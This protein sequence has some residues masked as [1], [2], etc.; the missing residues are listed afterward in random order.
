MSIDA[1]TGYCLNVELRTNQKLLGFTINEKKNYP[2]TDI[3]Q[4][5]YI[6]PIV[7]KKFNGGDEVYVI[8]MFEGDTMRAKVWGINE[9]EPDEWDI[10]VDDIE[11]I[12]GFAGVVG[13]GFN[14]N[15]KVTDFSVKTIQPTV[16]LALDPENVVGGGYVTAVVLAKGFGG[17]D[18]LLRSNTEGKYLDL[19]DDGG[20]GDGDAGDEVFAVSFDTSSYGSG[21]HEFSVLGRNSD[22]N[23]HVLDTA[24]LIVS[25]AQCERILGS[26]NNVNFVVVPCLFKE[27]ESARFDY[28]ADEIADTFR[29][30]EPFSTSLDLFS[31]YK[32]GRYDP[33]LI[34]DDYTEDCRAHTAKI[35][36]IAMT[37]PVDQIIVVAKDSG[38]ASGGY[39]MVVVPS[40]I[41]P[42][43]SDGRCPDWHGSADDVVKP[44]MLHEL[45]HALGNFPHTCGGN[46]EL[47][48]PADP[49]FHNP[50]CGE[51][52][53]SADQ[54]CAE[55]NN[56]EYLKW[57][58]MG[59]YPG[60]GDAG[61]KVVGGVT[62][63]KGGAH[64]DRFK[65]WPTSVNVMCSDRYLVNGYSPIEKKVLSD[66]LATG[67]V[68]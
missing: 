20:H 32:V 28:Y 22:D 6:A 23:Y 42:C 45:G 27:S 26:G 66:K 21:V 31:V 12:N 8:I 35:R 61:V 54:P 5:T 44:V 63:R 7:T 29:E 67:G 33:E 55:W 24:E 68:G 25:S 39:N 38:E 30:I 14:Q 1:I 59:C 17:K 2:V 46:P 41:P 16:I 62:V 52:Q 34:F 53:V 57:G 64:S 10:V 11:L 4:F 65:P 47:L 9:I 56:P 37:C 18:I 58:D 19:Y 36:E 49:G 40:G 51:I 48:V 60:C 13:K 3:A 43:A 50:A 15:Q